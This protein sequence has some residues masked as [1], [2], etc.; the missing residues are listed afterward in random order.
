MISTITGSIKAVE[1][2]LLT[3]DIGFLSLAVQVPLGAQFVK[4]KKVELFTHMHWN[5]EQG[6]TLF[7]FATELERMVFLLVI[8]CSGLG[9]KIALAVLADLGPQAFIQAVQQGNDKVLSK[10]SGIGAKKAEQVIVQLKHKVAKLVKSGVKLDGAAQLTQWNNITEVLESLNYSR[11]EITAAMK[12]LSNEY[13]GSDMPFDQLIRHA[14]S[15]LAKN[16]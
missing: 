11:A 8:S 1:G 7:G 14:L 16:K 9:P 3:V 6:P 15:F 5:Q 13:V 12:H 2:K 4:G 10:V